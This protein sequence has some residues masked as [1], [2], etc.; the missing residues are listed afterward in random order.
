MQ[1]EKSKKR[2][3][4]DKKTY[5]HSLARLHEDEQG[6]VEH[7]LAHDEAMFRIRIG[8]VARGD[9]E[10]FAHQYRRLAHAAIARIGAEV[11]EVEHVLRGGEQLEEQET[12]VLARRPVA[13]VDRGSVEQP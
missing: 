10:Q 2:P 1:K 4:L 7:L 11:A 6:E 12:I 13:G 9:L 3:R 5:E 8:V